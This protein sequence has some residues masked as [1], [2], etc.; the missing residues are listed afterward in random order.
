MLSREIMKT[1]FVCS[2]FAILLGVQTIQAGQFTYTSPANSSGNNFSVIQP[3]GEGAPVGGTNDVVFTWDGTLNDAVVGA[4]SNATLTSDEAFFGALWNAHDIMLY[5]PGSYTIFDACAPGDPGC[6][7]GNAVTF[8]VGANQIGAHMLFDWSGNTDIDV[9]VVW[10]FNN[11]WSNLNPLPTNPFYAGL[12][13]GTGCTTATGAP[14]CVIDGQPNT[15]ATSFNLVS[16][17][18]NGDGIAGSPMT[19]GPFIGF[20]VSFN[21]NGVNF[22]P[23][24]VDDNAGTTVDTPVDINVAANDSDFEDGTPPP[25]PPAAITVTVNPTNGGVVNNNNGTVTYTPNA[26]Y[27]GGDSF[28]Y[29]L[30]DSDGAVSQAATV[31]ITVTAVANNPPVANDV[32]FN[33]DEDTALDVDITDTD[34]N[35]TPVATD[36][37]NDPLTYASFDANTAEGGTVVVNSANT[38]L[39]YTPAQDFFGTD[40]FNFVV[41]D[42]TDDSNQATM[43]ITVNEVNDP[44]VCQD[45]NL[46]TDVDT[47]LDIDVDNDLLSTCTDVDDDPISLDSYTQPVEAGSMVTDDGAGTLTYTPANG[48]SGSDSFTYTATDG[49]D[50]AAPQTVTVEVGKAFG[51]FTM[52]DAG[53]T[54][55]GGTNDVAAT[56]DGSLNTDESDTN[57]NMTLGS[58]SDF[59]FFGFPWFAHD[60]RV[61]G[62]GSYSFD[63]SCSVQQIQSGNSGDCGNGCDANPDNAGCLKLDIPADMIGAHMLFDWN[64]TEDIDVVLLWEMD[65]AFVNPDA[66]GSLYLGPAGPTPP[67]DC[68][69]QLVSRDADGDT[70]PGAK[71]IDGPFIDFRANFNL[72]FTSGCTDTD[73]VDLDIKKFSTS[74]TVKLD[75]KQVSI[76]LTVS[77]NSAVDEPA[78]AQVIGI[79]N[80]GFI[81]YNEI[82]SVSDTPGN[83]ST[84][85]DFPA[86]T[87]AMTGVIDW[88][89]TIADDDP[90][91]DTASAVTTVK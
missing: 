43:T 15:D 21:I 8:T 84:R 2:L 73:P 63:S 34:D 23:T 89:V 39:T 36:D 76:S 86:Y 55:F 30:T 24:A 71:M 68:A 83:G 75:K 80:D 18:V 13:D 67:T 49:M 26:G 27:E 38:V 42:G 40:T 62:P 88:L 31:N 33:T 82:I 48:F 72:N 77:N 32:E 74:R 44:P 54:T 41:N 10:E 19:D 12:D 7:A 11:T 25:V 28:E 9:I 58:E 17:D 87:P 85:W 4:V 35:N 6:G 70:V 65:A 53:G 37:D 1:L 51:N 90:D 79:Q 69:Y 81:V 66:S 29:T 22:P 14:P 61:F 16:I 5:G 20:N 3:G 60:I 59:P 57:F 52:L 45:T 64:V 56:W 46:Y 78:N 50:M 47:P 91:D